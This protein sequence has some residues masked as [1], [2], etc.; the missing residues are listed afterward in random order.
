MNW[1]IG[2][3]ATLLAAFLIVGAA[4]ASAQVFTG[5]IDVT[6]ED[7]T[8][9]R[10]PGVNVDLTGPLN[11][12]QVTDAQGQAHFLNLT[13]GTYTVKTSLAGFNPYTNT[14]VVVAAGASTP[15]AIKLGVAGKAET[16]NVTAAPT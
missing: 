1:K 14:D 16:V 4:T 11:Q 6:V 12:T 9:G 10:L 8:G 13:P 7:A 5:R 3:L 2:K 15:M